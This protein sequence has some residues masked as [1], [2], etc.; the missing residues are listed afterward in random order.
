[1]ERLA[2][3]RWRPIGREDCLTLDV[4][5]PRVGYDSP[6]KVVVVVA[7]PSLAGGWP[8]SSIRGETVYVYKLRQLDGHFER[9]EREHLRA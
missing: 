7:A 9:C 3:G 5:T 6:S 4:F 2:D 1:M 8:D